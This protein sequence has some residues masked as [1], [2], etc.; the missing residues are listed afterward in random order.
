[1]PRDQLAKHEQF[2]TVSPSVGELD[3]AAFEQALDDNPDKALTLLVDMGKATDPELRATARALAARILL[4]QARRGMLRKAGTRRLRHIRADQG[5]D[6]DLDASLGAIAGAR[7]E[8]RPPGLD[9]LV[10]RDWGQPET[11][12]CL[13]IDTSGSMSGERLAAAALTA[14]ACAWRA[15]GDHAVLSFSREVTV[16]RPMESSR[17]A[18]AVVDSVLE[19]RGHGVTALATA[20]RAAGSQLAL[21]RAARKVVVLLSDCRVTDEQDP[22][23][24]AS[25]LPELLIL[26]PAEDTADA[27]ALALAS[28]ARWAGLPGASAAAQVLGQLLR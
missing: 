23:P 8:G 11:A 1:M 26:P 14:A 5:G 13:V 17:P 24:A 15:P 4:D 19:L 20:L 12:L 28:G 27:E 3:E 22:V 25:A 2:A 10:A 18:S 6:L 16:L 21:T 7:A 9:E